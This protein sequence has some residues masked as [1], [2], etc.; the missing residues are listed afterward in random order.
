MQMGIKENFHG[1]PILPMDGKKIIEQI[2]QDKKDWPKPTP[3]PLSPEETKEL[4]SKLNLK[5]PEEFKLY[6]QIIMQNHDV[7]SKT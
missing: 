2:E 3:K 4:L 5:V 7:F 1:K 6:E